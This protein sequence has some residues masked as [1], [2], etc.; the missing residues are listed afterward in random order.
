MNASISAALGLIG[1]RAKARPVPAAIARLRLPRTS[2]L[3]RLCAGD[4]ERLERLTQGTLLIQAGSYVARYGYPFRDLYA[5]R[6]GRIQASIP[7]AGGHVRLLGEF[8]PGDVIGFDALRRG[9]YP[10]DFV[11]LETS[12]VC[13]VPLHMLDALAA[14]QR[15]Q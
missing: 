13:R 11:T 12:T 7:D 3:G 9:T 6:S 10:A 4:L 5:V 2:Q 14:A 15:I 1:R 8:M